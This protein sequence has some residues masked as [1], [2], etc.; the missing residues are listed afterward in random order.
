MQLDIFTKDR[1]T[2]AA[3]N[4]IA[5]RG[6]NGYHNFACSEQNHSS[7]LVHLNDGHKHKI[8]YCKYV[9]TLVKDLL[10]HEHKYVNKWNNKLYD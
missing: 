4:L 3:Y 2:Y 5:K 1:G 7:L 6:N 10:W 8:Q 9:H